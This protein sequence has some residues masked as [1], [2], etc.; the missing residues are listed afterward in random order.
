MFR[1]MII[2]VDARI[3]YTQ[4]QALPEIITCL[5]AVCRYLTGEKGVENLFYKY[6][7]VK[8]FSYCSLYIVYFT[9]RRQFHGVVN[10]PVVALFHCC[11]THHSVSPIIISPITLSYPSCCLTHHAASPISL[12]HPSCCLPHHALSPIMLS[13]PSRCLPHPNVSPITLSP[14]HTV[15]PIT[16]SHSPPPVSQRPLLLTLVSDHQ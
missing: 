4:Q 11:L 9:V 8:F 6:T 15:S 14:H 13:H 2:N 1:I 3:I 12:S 5:R 7:L 16:L 10:E